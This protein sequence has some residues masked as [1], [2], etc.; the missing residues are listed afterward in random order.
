MAREHLGEDVTCRFD[1]VAVHLGRTGGVL[2]VEVIP[3]AFE[4]VGWH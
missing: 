2:A 1:V 4:A 3:D